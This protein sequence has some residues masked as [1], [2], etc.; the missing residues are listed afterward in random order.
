MLHC[1][2]NPLETGV[3]YNYFFN[4]SNDSEAN[5]SELLKNLEEMFQYYYVFSTMFIMFKP[6]TTHSV[7]SSVKRLDIITYM[8]VIIINQESF[9]FCF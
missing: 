5:D 1:Y 2:V 4:I 8:H 7:L 3:P 9:Q 6:L